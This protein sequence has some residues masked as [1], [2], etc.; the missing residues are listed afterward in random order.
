MQQIVGCI[1]YCLKHSTILLLAC[2]CISFSKQVNLRLVDDHPVEVQMLTS[3]AEPINFM[4]Q[5]VL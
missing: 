1:F 3:I 5:P 2:V 4:N